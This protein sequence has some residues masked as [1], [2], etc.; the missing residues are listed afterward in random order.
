MKHVFMIL[1]ISCK[2]TY[3]FLPLQQRY[4]LRNNIN[5]VEWDV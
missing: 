5:C 3:G 2:R 4:R 1:S